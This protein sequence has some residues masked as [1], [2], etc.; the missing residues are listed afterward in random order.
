MC[1]FNKKEVWEIVLKIDACATAKHKTILS[2][3]KTDASNYRPISVLLILS[4][5][6][7][8]PACVLSISKLFGAK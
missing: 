1:W 3:P 8:I 2:W 6:L 7:E 5:T 4:K